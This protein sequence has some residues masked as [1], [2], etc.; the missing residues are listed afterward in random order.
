VGISVAFDDATDCRCYRGQLVGGEINCRHGPDIIGRQLSSKKRG[1][2][3]H[4]GASGW[5]VIERAVSQLGEGQEPRLR[6][7]MRVENGPASS[8]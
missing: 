8:A 1:E 3:P 6:A 2:M 5:R 7:A 4:G